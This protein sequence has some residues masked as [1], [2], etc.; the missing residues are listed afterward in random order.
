M[1]YEDA[2]N[3]DALALEYLRFWLDREQPGWNEAVDAIEM[4]K[5]QIQQAMK[6]GRTMDAMKILL[7]VRE[8]N[9]HDPIADGLASILSNDRS[10]F[11]KLVRNWC[12]VSIPCWKNLP[13]A[14]PR[15]YCLH[16]RT[17]RLIQGRSSTG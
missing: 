5:T 9:L 13:P 7:F 11:E 12:P 6:S 10:Y 4:D 1:I 17:T 2:V 14:K 8:N 3:I 16:S 15:R